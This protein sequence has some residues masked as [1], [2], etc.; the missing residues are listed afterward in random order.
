MNECLFTR[1][2][3]VI[4]S[5]SFRI[6]FDLKCVIFTLTVQ[7]EKNGFLNGFVWTAFKSPGIIIDY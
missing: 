4:S 3:L 5:G 6:V 2:N 1:V 7:L